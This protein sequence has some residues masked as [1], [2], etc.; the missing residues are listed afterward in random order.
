MITSLAQGLINSIPLLI[1]YVPQII[2]SFCAAIDTGLLQLIAAGVK[3]IA[4][5]VI[6]IVQAIP[7]LIA[8]LPQIVLAIVNV[9]L[10]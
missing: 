4:N 9:L 5:L 1:E 2:N 3:I 10:I 8:A 6:G 7:Q